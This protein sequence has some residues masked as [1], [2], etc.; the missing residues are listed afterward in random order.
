[1]EKLIEKFITDTIKSGIG[2]MI[3][4]FGSWA[5][6]FILILACIYYCI[7]R[8]VKLCVNKFN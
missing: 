7:F 4:A 1:M 3:I 6:V 8:I 2:Q 5:Y